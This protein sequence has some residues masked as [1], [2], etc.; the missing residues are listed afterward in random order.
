MVAAETDLLLPYLP[1]LAREWAEEPERRN[2]LFEGT[3]VFADLSG[4][5]AMTERL[6]AIGRRGAEEVASIISATFASMLVPVYEAGGSLLKFGGDALFLL[7]KGSHHERAAV[8]AAW[9]MRGILKNSSVVETTVGKVRL[10]MTT[11]LSSGPIHAFSAGAGTRE[12]LFAGPTVT[13]LMNLERVA[14]A[15]QTLLCPSTA[16]S[17]PASL[18]TDGP[19]GY[20]RLA[21]RPPPIS[22]GEEVLDPAA[23]GDVAP[24]VSAAVHRRIADGQSSP[25]HRRIAIGFVGVS[26]LDRLIDRDPVEA[27]DALDALVAGAQ[28]AAA[29]NGAWLLASDV[30]V[31]GAKLILTAG[32]P[33]ATGHDDASLLLTL[34]ELVKHD[35]PLTIRL[36][37]NHGT[38]FF[39]D[40]GPSYR[41]TLTVMG[42]T[43]N[44]A[45]RLMGAAGEGSVLGARTM[46]EGRHIAFDHDNIRTISLRGRREPLEVADIF[47]PTTAG[48]AAATGG[49]V[50][51]DAELAEFEGLLDQARQGRGDIVEVTGPP[52]SGRSRLVGEVLS[53]AGDVA[54]VRAE[55]TLYERS[56]P[57]AVV[58]RLFEQL[59]GIDPDE[60]DSSVRLIEFTDRRVS[61]LGSDV[62][63][64]ARA[65]GIAGIDETPIEATNPRYLQAITTR[66]IVSVLTACEESPLVMAIDDAH[67][68]DSASL[69]I[70]RQLGAAAGSLGWLVCVTLPEPGLIEWPG[71]EPKRVSLE[72][73]DRSSLIELAT[74]MTEDAPLASHELATIVDRAEG[75]PLVL[76]E[77]IAARRSATDISAI[78]TAVEGLMALRIDQLEPG[79]RR[80]LEVAS[81]LGTVFDPRLYEIVA[82][83]SADVLLTGWEDGVLQP[84]AN[85]RIR[86]ANPLL[87]DVVYDRLPF[88]YRVDLHRTVADTLKEDPTA[89]EDLAF[90]LYRAERW[91]EAVAASIAAGR[92][93]EEHFASLEAVQ[94]YE[95][96]LASAS[97]A[98]LP[99]TDTLDLWTRIGDLKERAGQFEG[100]AQ[101]FARAEALAPTLQ[102]RARLLIRRA[103][104]L[105]KLGRYAASLQCLTR[106]R[107]MAPDA[108][109]VV[110][111]AI[112]RYGG[113]RYYQGK[114]RDAISLARDAISESG[115]ESTRS[116]EAL[117][118]MILDMARTATGEPI[119]GSASRRAMEIFSELGDLDRQARVTN[120]LGM[121]AFFSGDWDEAEQMYDESRRIFERIGDEVN[122]AYGAANLA[123]IWAAQGRHAEAEHLFQEVRRIWRAADDKYGAA[124]IEGQLGIMA[125]FAGR[126][127]E[128]AVRIARSI[129]EFQEIGARAELAEAACH[130]VEMRLLAGDPAGARELIEF[131]DL[132]AA[133][134]GSPRLRRLTAVVEWSEGSDHCMEAISR[135]IDLAREAGADL[136]EL[137]L[138]ELASRSGLP[139]ADRGRQEQLTTSLGMVV[140]PVYPMAAMA[141]S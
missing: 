68:M 9:E 137:R 37:A 10:G 15:G 63:F 100:A 125:A 111:M 55:A 116:A 85:G 54:V 127:E 14:T 2:D 107:K 103:R 93:A 134:P 8:W 88:S 18:L 46:L 1:R 84:A 57:Y 92:D 22:T 113:V 77:I 71:S 64:V 48:G 62:A 74:A 94:W 140:S 39:G 122:A 45:A 101:A 75:N 132:E 6:S 121:F 67:L 36:G 40:V 123:E 105:E 17:V 32:A 126:S 69:G 51:R 24:F 20:A 59:T 27:A 7:F 73:L 97:H 41:R 29:A 129:A 53:R 131:Y 13:N 98:P 139:I 34:T 72:P 33:V 96:A 23:G 78:P 115:P 50:G 120:N 81:V 128:A 5:T 25:E 26:G 87:R 114:H 112:A 89:V 21:R 83:S 76:G 80:Q 30:A 108:P 61:A 130:L 133:I 4:F 58:R 138:L 86:F 141:T 135:A 16:V 35:T 91:P 3:L 104:P 44:T 90:H 95:T 42:D 60:D 38:V 109:D 82:Q 31:D 47:G 136:D 79:R 28:E 102:E 12:L 43:V 65:L 66:A 110:A 117:A 56:I 106:A 70:V 49:L 124:Y 119:D 118:L 11:A 99:A 52:G 19:M